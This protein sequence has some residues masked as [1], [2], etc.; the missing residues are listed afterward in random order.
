M[1]VA[2]MCKDCI[3][4]KKQKGTNSSTFISKLWVMAML[5]IVILITF[6]TLLISKEMIP[7]MRK[8][9]LSDKTT[10]AQDDFLFLE[11][12]VSLFEFSSKNNFVTP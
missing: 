5:V 12:V 2:N 9:Q 3:V 1:Y 4:F 10:K 6:L 11:D 8:D 7:Y